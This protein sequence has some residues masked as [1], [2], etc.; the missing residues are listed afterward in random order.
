M[1]GGWIAGTYDINQYIEVDM[2]MAYKFTKLFIQGRAD[3]DQWVTSFKILFYNSTTGTWET[4]MNA[5][6]TEVCILYEIF[7]Y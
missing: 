2:N 7:L 4:Y 1:L 3:A 5:A 6:G